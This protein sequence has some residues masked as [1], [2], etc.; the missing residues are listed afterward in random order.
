[1]T[2]GFI[3]FAPV[4]LDSFINNF[5]N[6]YNLYRYKLS[7]DRLTRFTM[8]DGVRNRSDGLFILTRRW[9]E[10]AR[11]R[12]LFPEPFYLPSDGFVEVSFVV[13]ESLRKKSRRKHSAHRINR[14]EF[15]W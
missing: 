11:G 9:K 13:E 14:M 4:R 6:L 15:N 10:N 2:S 12:L 1:M 7:C 5:Y 8:Q 3:I